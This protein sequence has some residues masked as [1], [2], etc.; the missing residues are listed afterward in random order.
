[1]VKPVTLWVLTLALTHKFPIQQLV[2]NNVFLNVFLE[3]VV[4]MTQP[5]AFE[6]GDKSMLCKL[7]KAIYGL[8]QAPRNWYD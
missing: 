7:H 6:Q 4:Y 2:I 5:T 1:M 8:K 3:E